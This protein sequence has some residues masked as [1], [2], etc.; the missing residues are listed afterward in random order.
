V[1][2]KAS[3]RASGNQAAQAPQ[4]DALKITA[5]EMPCLNARCE[6]APSTAPAH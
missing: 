3:S 6:D 5:G 1:R 4:P 2:S